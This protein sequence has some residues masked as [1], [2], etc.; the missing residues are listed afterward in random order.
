MDARASKLARALG[1]DYTT[2]VKLVE[3]GFVTENRAKGASKKELTAISG[4][5]KKMAEHIRGE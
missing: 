5:G 2:A 1:V 3:A 4:I